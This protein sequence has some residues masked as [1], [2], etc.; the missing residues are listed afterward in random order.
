MRRATYACLLAV[1]FLACASSQKTTTPRRSSHLIT[2][3]EIAA[4]SARNA[5][6]AIQMLRPSWLIMRGAA[7]S[8]LRGESVAP[9]VYSDNVRL[10]DLDNLRAIT[11]SDI[12][13]IEFLNSRDATTRFGTGYAGGAILVTTK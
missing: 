5:Y 12:A 4:S 9:V 8:T 10:G 11:A 13:T 6:D 3:E 1:F 7:S 2:V